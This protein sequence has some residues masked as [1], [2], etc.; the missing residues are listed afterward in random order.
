MKHKL[1]MEQLQYKLCM[2]H[3]HFMTLLKAASPI[4]ANHISM[5]NVAQSQYTQQ[6]PGTANIILQ[7]IIIY[8]VMIQY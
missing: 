3:S 2:L 4:T 8:S 6:R 7:I 1:V 5:S